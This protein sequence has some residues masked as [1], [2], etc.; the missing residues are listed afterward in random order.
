MCLD[1]K[2]GVN[3]ISKSFDLYPLSVLV[4]TVAFRLSKFDDVAVLDRSML[5]N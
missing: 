2:V 4:D 1:K 5:I 3:L